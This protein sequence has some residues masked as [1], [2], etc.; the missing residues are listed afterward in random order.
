M[1][2]SDFTFLRNDQQLGYFLRMRLKSSSR[3]N[4]ALTFAPQASQCREI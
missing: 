2:V 3:G 1:K 4:E